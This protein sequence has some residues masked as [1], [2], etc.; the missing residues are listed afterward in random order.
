M[1]TGLIHQLGTIR[2]RERT[3]RGERLT[4]EAPGW[5]HRP[6]T[7]DSIAVNGCCLTVADRSDGL[8]FDVIPTTLARTTLGGLAPGDRV[9]L[10]H[11]ATPSTLLG[12]HLV[13][14]HVDGVGEVRFNGALDDGGWELR[15]APPETV[16]PYL[17]ERGSI[18]I[19]GVSLTI[20]AWCEGTLTVALI[21][22]TLERTTLGGLRNG[23]SVNL[24]PDCLAKM[25]ATL[26]DQ[27]GLVGGTPD[28]GAS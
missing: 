16:A 14:G 17:V 12:G 11:A 23:D 22:E 5:S 24:E 28:P 27:R 21:P 7:G 19:E 20:A 26:L 4:L 9:H 10:E 13:Q 1:F 8:A 15:I 2:S 25:V 3:D 6:A 18:A